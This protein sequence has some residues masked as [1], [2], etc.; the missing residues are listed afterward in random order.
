M[1]ILKGILGL[2]LKPVSGVLDATFCLVEG[3]YN[4]IK[5]FEDGPSNVRKRPPRIFFDKV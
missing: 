1:G 5:V 4:M 2:I 3:I